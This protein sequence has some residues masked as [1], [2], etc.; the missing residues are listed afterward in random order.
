MR[1]VFLFLLWP[2]MFDPA[3]LVVLFVV[4]L[5]SPSFDSWD[6]SGYDC[7]DPSARHCSS[8]TATTAVPVH[9]RRRPAARA[10]S[11]RRSDGGAS[12]HVPFRVDD[13]CW[14]IR[15]YLFVGFFFLFFLLWISP[16]PK[17]VF[18]FLVFFL[19]AFAAAQPSPFGALQMM[20]P[21][22]L[23]QSGVS[24]RLSV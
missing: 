24:L 14:Y 16:Q 2:V 21:G 7:S 1:F 11:P 15:F 8:T 17:C 19:V 13:E 9:R 20:A 4:F 18:S 10:R 3:L 22:G 12:G 5:I 6:F 23:L